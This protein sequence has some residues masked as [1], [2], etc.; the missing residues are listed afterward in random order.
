MK[1]FDRNLRLYAV[2]GA[3]ALITMGLW[4]RLVQVQVFE[5]SRYARL[6]ADQATQ[7]REVSAVRGCI[8]DRN[9][10]PLALSARSFSVAVQPKQVVDREKVVSTLSKH[11]SVSKDT[12]RKALR[13]GKNFV[14]VKRR[15][16]LSKDAQAQLRKLRGVVLETQAD[17]VHPYETTAAKVVGFVGI[18]GNGMAGIE[19]ALDGEL[20]GTPGWEKIQRDGCYRPMEY[21]TL[22][23]KAP[24]NGRHVY[25]T[26]DARLQEIAEMELD[27]AVRGSGAAG[28]GVLIMDCRTGEILALAE[29]PSPQSASQ[30]RDESLWTLRSVSCVFEPGSTFKLITAAALL[31][32]G[33][34]RSSDV[35]DAENGRA[36][37]DV[38]VVRDA[39][40]YGPLTFEEA[41]VHSSNIVMAKAALRL[42]PEKFL[43]TI[44]LFGFGSPTGIELL[45]ESPG[46]VAPRYSRRTH[47]T[48]AYGHEIAVTP[49]QLASAY[50]AAANGGMLVMPRILRAIEDETTGL[51]TEFKPVELRRVMS[52]KTAALLRNYC[53]SVVTDGTGKPADVACVEVGGK[54]GTA[55]K[56]SAR[57]GYENGKFVSSFIGFAPALDPKIVCLV[58]I[59]EPSFAHRT[60]SLCAAPAF[61]NIIETIASSSH[62]LDDAVARTRAEREEE[63][64]RRVITPNFLRMTR[65][66]V[67]QRAREFDLNLLCQ[68]EGEV[69]AQDPDPGV[70]IDRDDVLRVYLSGAS[71]AKTER[72]VPDLIGATVRTAKRSA[73]ESGFKCEISGGGRVVSQWPAPGAVSKS[74]IVRVECRDETGRKTG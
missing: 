7:E 27:E 59:D 16:D 61:G 50:A 65:D 66:A 40:P 34:V 35:F 55:Q 45:G 67:M 56:P 13:S 26:I 19:A 10:S 8:F 15:C 47:L 46:Q 68:G 71:G 32:A 9:G 21:Q 70:P 5:S 58:F 29:N 51:R 64:R 57:G 17:R 62:V 41:F 18:D 12:I 72:K 63:E 53:R 1:K 38:A 73:A 3:F 23:E 69:I 30:A 22:A 42:E 20:R 39:H 48:L 60:G 33:K 14:Y 43:E 25:L 54:T 2:G 74:G 44:R 31:E 28:G 4:L 6:A 36:D 52:E 11:L 24:V 49:L 37:L